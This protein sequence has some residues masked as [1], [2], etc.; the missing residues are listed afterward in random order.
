M[1]TFCISDS[2]KIKPSR[3]KGLDF[4]KANHFLDVF[5]GQG[6]Y[7][8]KPSG[9]LKCRASVE[10]ASG[11]ANFMGIPDYAGVLVETALRAN[12]YSELHVLS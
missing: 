11:A 2:S 12:Y 3:K 10:K 6:K 7:T 9:H 8:K 1:A 4:V 5:A